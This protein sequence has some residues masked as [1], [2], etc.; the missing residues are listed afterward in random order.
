MFFAL[1]FKIFFHWWVV[2]L[3]VSS[4]ESLVENLYCLSVDSKNIGIPSL[5][6][7]GGRALSFCLILEQFMTS[8]I[9]GTKSVF[10]KLFK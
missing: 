7:F 8:V 2:I 5:L 9:A 4:V 3:F 1:S 10:T 6:N